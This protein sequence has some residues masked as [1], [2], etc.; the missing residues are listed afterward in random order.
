MPLLRTSAAGLAALALDGSLGVR[1]DEQMRHQAGR[2]PGAAEIRSWE[3]SL[4]VIAQDLVQAGLD[5]IEV[6]VEHSLPLSS[7]RVDVILAGQ[8][9]RTRQPSYVVVELKQWSKATAWEGDSHLVVVD[10]YGARPHVHPVAQVRGYCQ[11]LLEFTTAL[12]DNPAAVVGAAYLH[13]AADRSQSKTSTT[14]H[15]ISTPASSWPPTVASGCASCSR[16]STVTLLE[17]HTRIT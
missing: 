8:H 11:Y 15:R 4:P 17:L 7:K 13:N 14:S 3:R 9:P 16:T 12:H 2:R 1:I 10:G 6:I 5:K